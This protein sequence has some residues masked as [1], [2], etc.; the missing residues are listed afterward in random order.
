MYL[1]MMWITLLSAAMFG[2]HGIVA[3]QDDGNLALDAAVANLQA[4]EATEPATEIGAAQDPEKAAPLNQYMWQYDAKTK[5]LTGWHVLAPAANSNLAWVDA[6]ATEFWS[7]LDQQGQFRWDSKANGDEWPGAL[8]T[9]D[10]EGRLTVLVNGKEV[11]PDRLRRQGDSVDVLGDDGSVRFTFRNS[12]KDVQLP[13][14][15][16][17]YLPDHRI[18]QATTRPLIGI[19]MEPASEALAYHCGVETHAVVITR[20]VPGMSAEKSGLEKFDVVVG[21]GSDDDVT[22]ESFKKAVAEN[23]GQSI[24]LRVV[25]KGHHLVI[26]VPV[27]RQAVGVE[28]NSSVP[29]LGDIPVVGNLFRRQG[30][31]PVPTDPRQGSWSKN[32]KENQA[33]YNYWRPRLA[34]QNRAYFDSR[35][36]TRKRGAERQE[37]PITRLENRLERLERLIEKHYGQPGS[38]RRRK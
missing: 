1:R 19:N 11:D 8:F 17:A 30:S 5:G 24:Q 15:A 2:S 18:Q 32:A 22:M 10:D 37:D 6:S 38:E 4:G 21:I 26:D 35:N 16:A 13:P 36:E 12:N 25:R 27:V 34:E 23:G 28:K 29:L 33:L 7:K 20:V 9:L 3:A 31:D 14:G